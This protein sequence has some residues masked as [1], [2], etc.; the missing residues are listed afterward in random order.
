[1]ERRAAALCMIVLA[2]TASAGATTA[3]TFD[4]SPA[5]PLADGMVLTSQY[6]SLGVEFTGFENGVE[7]PTYVDRFWGV[8]PA[9]GNYW[10]NENS[11]HEVANDRRD[12]LEV[13]FLGAVT[14]VGFDYI[15]TW[16]IEPVVVNLYDSSDAFIGHVNI[17]THSWNALDLSSY[18]NI[19][20]I[21]MLQPWDHF[22][23]ALDNLRFDFTGA[24]VPAPAALALGTLGAGLVGWLRRRRA[25]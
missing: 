23:F 11:R 21:R 12:V 19:A 6:A 2:T 15:N 14:N 9:G 20:Y 22:T 13:R 4:D 18:S 16:S 1:M 10:T 5:G 24:V 3:I 25:L 8:S 17:A 7:M